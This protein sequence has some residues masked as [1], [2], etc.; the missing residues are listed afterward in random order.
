MDNVIELNTRPRPPVER[1]PQD[2]TAAVIFFPGVRYERF[3]EA[4]Q[5]AGHVPAADRRSN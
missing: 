2:A 4:T 3:R 5:P 1:P